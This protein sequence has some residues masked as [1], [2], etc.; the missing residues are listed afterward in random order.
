MVVDASACSPVLPPFASER[1]SP[2]PAEW[3]IPH[4]NFQVAVYIGIRVGSSQSQAILALQAV[5]RGW[6]KKLSISA[7]SAEKR[8]HPTHVHTCDAG[9]KSNALRCKLDV[10]T[11]GSRRMIGTFRAG[12]ADGVS[13]AR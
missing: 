13:N 5:A 8:R 7:V 4:G 10:D 11:E 12:V 1:R 2:L 3:E 6:Y 9:S